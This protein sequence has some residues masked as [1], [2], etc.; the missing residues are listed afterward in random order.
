LSQ[1]V[2]ADVSRGAKLERDNCSGCHAARFDGDM[3][4]I[5][6]RQN[7]RVNNYNRLVSQVKFC[8]NN[9]GLTWFEDQVMDVVKHLNQNYY[10]F[11]PNK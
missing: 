9:L 8:K 5:Y 2:L 7:R 4:A 6:L 11:T 3:N 1:S 10:H